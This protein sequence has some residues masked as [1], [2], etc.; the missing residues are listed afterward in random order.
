MKP[1]LL[2]RT[3]RASEVSQVLAALDCGESCTV[4]GIGSVGK[5]NLLRFLQ[6]E[7]VHQAYLNKE[8]AQFLFAHVD[9][10]KM[11]EHSLWGLWELMLHQLVVGLT[12]READ[13]AALQ[14][15][16]ELYV[17]ATQQETRYLALRY[18]DRAVNTVCNQLGLRLVYLIDEFDDL[19]RAM[20]SRGFSALRA[21]RDDHKY[22]LMYV[23][24]TRLEFDHLR[25]E[26][27][28]IESF[29]ELVSI[30]TIWLGP[31]SEADAR[32]M[33]E[34]L[35]ERHKTCLDEQTIDYLLAATGGH[36]GLLRAAYRVAAERPG[37]LPR[38]LASAGLVQDEC[39]RIWFSLPAAEQRTVTRLAA[40]VDL[41][42]SQPS[43]LQ[44]LRLKGVAGGPWVDDD[45]IFSPLLADY[46]RTQQPSIGAR[47]QVD[48]DRRTVWVDGRLI[49]NLPPLEYG[50]IEYLEAN[51]GQV[52]SRD[53][54]AQHLY[55]E[56]ALAE[57]VSDARLDAVAKRAR[58]RI[59][60][61]RG[62]QRYIE[63]VWGQGFRLNDG[64]EDSV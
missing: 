35:E 47:V 50:F 18:L 48:R 10:N 55:P 64:A 13:K 2:P 36:P 57:G 62:Q 11:L 15:T 9:G 39:R 29:E 42:T 24:A 4:L 52:C 43:I 58:K 38:E 59:E 49:R 3:F 25:E 63:T 6:R 14:S 44:R 61:V 16:D 30:N 22:R 41:V 26:L 46:V 19:C 37:D 34:R 60:P 7:D 23:V 28:E 31:Y 56:D 40:T 32:F 27:A 20:P 45:S 54:L 5:S 8:R 12:N 21:L 53:E 1:Q 51:R 33:L 17:R